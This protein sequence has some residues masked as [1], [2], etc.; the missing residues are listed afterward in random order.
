MTI[1]RVS[2]SR[3]EQTHLI[4]P[5]DT[6]HHNTLFGGVLMQIIDNVSSICFFRHTRGV[7]GVTASMDNLNF[8]A[9]LPVSHA[10]T[11][12]AMMSGTGN[13]SGEVFCKVIGENLATGERYL[14]ATAFLTFVAPADDLKGEK[15][16]DITADTE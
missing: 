15:I 13:S 9:P 12:S 5:G 3:V 1:K 2:E 6:N 10:V 4:L 7:L 8:I 14:A 16:A 11:V